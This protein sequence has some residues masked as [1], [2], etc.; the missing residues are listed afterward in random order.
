[1]YISNYRT[2]TQSVS[3]IQ[4]LYTLLSTHS[5]TFPQLLH[6]GHQRTLHAILSKCLVNPNSHIKFLTIAC[7]A[8]IA[9]HET[10]DDSQDHP[11]SLFEG[12]K[13]AKVLKLTISTVLGVLARP[14]QA[15]AEIIRLC[16]VSVRAINAAVV[17]A[18]VE[19]RGCPQQ[20]VKLRE[21]AGGDLNGEILQ[22]V[23]VSFDLLNYSTLNSC[24]V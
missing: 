11:Q 6:T 22:A 2:R 9:Q 7:L 5:N 14:N 15:S 19:Q 17:E 18:W 8:E 10:F 20:L 1:M 21:R 3:N 12:V 16:G 13:G 23:S 4:A 24:S